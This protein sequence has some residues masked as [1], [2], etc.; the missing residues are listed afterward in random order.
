MAVQVRTKLNA[1]GEKYSKRNNA[2]QTGIANL[3]ACSTAPG[4]LRH[5]LAGTDT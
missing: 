4:I 5:F 2:N 3:R 1:Q